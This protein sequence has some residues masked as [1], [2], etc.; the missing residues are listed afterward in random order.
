MSEINTEEYW[1][2][3]FLMDWEAMQGKEQTE[4]FAYIALELLPDW[5]KSEIKS[6]K[7]T[8]CDFG[9]ALGEAVCVLNTQLQTKVSGM[10]FSES[11]VE[12]AKENYPQYDFFQK[13]ISKEEIEEMR[14]D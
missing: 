4:F 8:I 1:D 7:L 6:E 2:N 9:C 3:R 11:A 14:F 10:D 13:D 5:L 12:K